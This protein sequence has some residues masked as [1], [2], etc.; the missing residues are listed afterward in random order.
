LPLLAL[1]LKLF[2]LTLPNLNCQAEFQQNSKFS[3]LFHAESDTGYSGC[4]GGIGWD[5][6]GVLFSIIVLSGGAI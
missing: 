5:P 1:K 6:F 3:S 4:A 2:F